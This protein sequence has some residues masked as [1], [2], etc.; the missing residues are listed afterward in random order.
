MA[1]EDTNVELLRDTIACILE[2]VDELDLRTER[3][4]E[5]EVTTEKT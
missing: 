3:L 4:P 2:I 5:E 1:L